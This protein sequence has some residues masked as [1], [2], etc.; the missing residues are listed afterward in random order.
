[1]PVRRPLNRYR[2][3]ANAAQAEMNSDSTDDTMAMTIELP[4]HRQKLVVSNS[5]VKFSVLA[6]RGINEEELKVPS[7]LNAADT[8]NRI[9]KIA[10][11]SAMIPTMCRQPT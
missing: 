9:G 5:L 4:N 1:M 11:M 7:G 6:F 8:T 3:N 10:K 2:E